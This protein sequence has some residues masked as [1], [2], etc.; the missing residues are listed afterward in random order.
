MVK[1]ETGQAN[2]SEKSD[3][4]GSSEVELEAFALGSGLER[5]CNARA[6]AA[7]RVGHIRRVEIGQP[8]GQLQRRLE[9]VR[10]PR[11]DP[12]ADDDPVDHHLDVV[13]VL[14]VERRR[15]LDRVELAVDADAG[16]AGLLPFGQLLAIF[17]LAA[18][19]DGG[20][21]IVARSFG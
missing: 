19:D 20:E 15:L 18:A 5:C 3:A 6:L 12:F 2:F 11:L 14:L 7:G 4:A 21:Q 16:E 10:Q 8:L 1:P 13:L 9:A 17:A